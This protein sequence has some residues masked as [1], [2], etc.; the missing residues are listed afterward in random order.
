MSE[1]FK[2]QSQCILRYLGKFLTCDNDEGT[3]G[4]NSDASKLAGDDDDADQGA[5]QAIHYAGRKL[6]RNRLGL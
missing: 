6:G 1:G 2:L 3:I 4:D 5:V